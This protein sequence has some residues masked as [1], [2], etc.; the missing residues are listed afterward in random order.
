MECFWPE[1]EGVLHEFHQFPRIRG[2]MVENGKNWD[3]TTDF[4]AKAQRSKGAKEFTDHAYV[5]PSRCLHCNSPVLAGREDCLRGRRRLTESW[6]GRIIRTGKDGRIPLPMIL[7]FP[8][9][10]ASLRLCVKI[11]P[12][13][14][15]RLRMRISLRRVVG[16]APS[17]PWISIVF[18]SSRLAAQ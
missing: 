12:H 7:P 18:T 5:C 1:I 13:P 17:R 6:Q 11:P 2:K 16:A 14:F 9:I 10:F 15:L 4:N 8:C 3:L